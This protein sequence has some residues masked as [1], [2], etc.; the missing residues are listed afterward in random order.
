MNSEYIDLLKKLHAEKTPSRCSAKERDADFSG[1][2]S[3]LDANQLYIDN[4]KLLQ[5]SDDEKIQ[6]CYVMID[7][8]NSLK[9]TKVVLGDLPWEHPYGLNAEFVCQRITEFDDESVEN[10]LAG[11]VNFRYC[12]REAKAAVAAGVGI[13]QV[14]GS[15]R[16]MAH[17]FYEDKNE[18]SADQEM[19]IHFR[20][21]FNK[22]KSKEGSQGFN[23]S[24][25]WKKFVARHIRAE[26]TPDHIAS[27]YHGLKEGCE[28]KSE[29][30]HI[31]NFI[32]RHGLRMDHKGR[33]LGEDDITYLIGDK[34]VN[35]ETGE[36]GAIVGTDNDLFAINTDSGGR[37][38]PRSVVS[39]DVQSKDFNSE[40]TP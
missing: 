11:T 7:V 4:K 23:A 24:E 30:L 8:W 36:K 38:W 32:S 33:I 37:E 27:F 21:D 10:A 28:S 17:R 9:L 1:L 40:M 29:E 25:E 6:K 20:L 16:E 5:M 15:W 35:L 19:S 34:I 22:L 31:L 2:I 13:H 3:F 26:F 18:S 14:Y 39:L 12:T